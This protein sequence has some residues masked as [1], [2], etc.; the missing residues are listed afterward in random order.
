MMKTVT[1]REVGF[2]ERQSGALGHPAAER[3]KSKPPRAKPARGAPRF[4]LAVKPGAPAGP[5]MTSRSV[6]P[7]ECAEDHFE[8]PAP[9]PP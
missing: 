8:A 7:V 4:V 3:K 2:W 9:G 5:P 1:A 6:S